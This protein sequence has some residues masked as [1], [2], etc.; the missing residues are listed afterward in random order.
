MGRFRSWQRILEEQ[1]GFLNISS[2]SQVRGV[3]IVKELGGGKENTFS[4]GECTI[5]PNVYFEA[6]SS[7]MTMHECQSF[8]QGVTGREWK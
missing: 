4:F 3:D 1:P 6:K 8:D 5:L 2:D 7:K